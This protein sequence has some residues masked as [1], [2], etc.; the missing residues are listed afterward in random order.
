M[1]WL[2]I[3]GIAFGL[4][5]DATAVSIAAGIYIHKV[6][7]RHILRMAF[8]FGLFQAV[9]PVIGWFAGTRFASSIASWDHWVAF[10][11]LVVIGGKMIWECFEEK[12]AELRSDPSR[13]LLLVSL[14]IATSIDALAVG[15][16]F[17]MLGT[18]ILIPALVIGVITG[19]L[20]ALGVMFGDRIGSRWERVATFIGG[21]VLIGIGIKVLVEHTL[22]A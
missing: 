5:M 8:H 4:A 12:D 2:L 16:S 10:G 1:S 14:S 19:I 3:T 22:L 13:G 21:I 11:V 9:M 20:S 18:G 17:A 6:T 7:R 15:V